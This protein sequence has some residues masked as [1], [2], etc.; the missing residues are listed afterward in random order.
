L[1]LKAPLYAQ[2]ELTY[3]CNLGC[4]HCYNEPRF[5]E[6][7]GTL[8][9]NRV[10]VEDVPTER[11]T[12]IAETLAENDVFAAT[13]TGGEVFTVRD[14]LFPAIETLT[15]HDL[16]TTVNSN[17][18]L[19]KEDDAKRLRDLQIG[20]VMTSL[21]SFNPDIHNKIM[22]KERAHQKTIRG[23]ELLQ[24]Q[25]IYVTANMVVSQNNKNDVLLEFL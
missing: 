25:G 16:E 8:K 3:A 14:R 10:K 23:I 21:A 19:L 11:F 22:N 13:L 24:K 6:D 20:G 4:F 15:R 1:K 5:S 12:E 7:N 2:I 18:T 17:L 9:L